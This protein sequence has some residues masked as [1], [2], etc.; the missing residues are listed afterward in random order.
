[1]SYRFF[2]QSTP[3]HGKMVLEGEQARHAI[4]ALS[5][6]IVRADISQFYGSLYTHSLPWALHTKAV[7][8]ASSSV[9]ASSLRTARR[10]RQRTS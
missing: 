5:P 8:K 10:L 6:M 2:T 3:N 1:M 7:A 9:I 4:R